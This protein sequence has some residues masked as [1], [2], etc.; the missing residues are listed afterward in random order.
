MNTGDASWISSNTLEQE[1]MSWLHLRVRV[2]QTTTTGRKS[3]SV[4]GLASSLPSPARNIP[5]TR[6]RHLNSS[7]SI[8]VQ[9]SVPVDADGI[10]IAPPYSIR[11]LIA[12]LPTPALSDEQYIHLHTLSSLHPPPSGSPEFAAKKAQLQ[13]MIRLVEAVRDQSKSDNHEAIRDHEFGE[14]PD[15][16]IWPEPRFDPDD[17]HCADGAV[18]MKLDWES[19]RKSRKEAQKAFEA[20]G[21]GG[22]DL[23]KLASKRTAGYYSTARKQSDG[24]E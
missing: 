9:R 6:S 16:R 14:I 8:V 10:P 12:S 23:L 1:D 3:H 21:E 2:L 15:G 4:D 20:A 13:E 7:R 24:V 11:A 17:P 22:R 5:S 19:V 18:G